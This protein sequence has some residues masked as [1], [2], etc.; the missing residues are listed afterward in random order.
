MHMTKQD[1][2]K[3]SHTAILCAHARA[4][5]T[6]IPFAKKIYETINNKP[7]TTTFIADQITKYNQN[8]RT[9]LSTLEGRYLAINDAIAK[10]K[11]SNII[12]IASGISTRGLEYADKGY[13]YIETDLPEM[14]KL[15]ENLLQKITNNQIQSNHHF[16]S[17]NAL[18]Q[19]ELLATGKYMRQLSPE[20]S[21]ALIQEGLLMY[22][23]K[24]EQKKLRD[25]IA[26]FLDKYSPNGTWIT[27]DLSSREPKE[28]KAFK[29]IMNLISQNTNRK[30]K[31]F[32]DDSEAKEFLNEGGLTGAPL[33][34]EPYIKNLSYAK[35]MRLNQ[36]QISQVS[37]H[38][39]AW[40]ISL[41]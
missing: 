15:K 23:A 11:S 3:I 8:F 27:T 16:R 34:N 2:A 38:Y 12:E 17:L 35:K 4:K 39:R 31:R 6:N 30:F 33:P 28:K 32:S 26:T 10:S 41:K 20:G 22:L 40:T 37:D 5:Y 25:N 13:T 7:R 24:S 19:N 36:N 14:I 9:Q 18:N 21:I 29:L 1:F